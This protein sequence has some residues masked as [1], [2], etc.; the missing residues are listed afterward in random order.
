MQSE[1][2]SINHR[3][4]LKR[5]TVN[6]WGQL[7]YAFM[8]SRSMLCLRVSQDVQACHY[9]VHT[10]YTVTTNLSSV[11]LPMVHENAVA[12][13]LYVPHLV[14]RA[15]GRAHTGVH[16]DGKPI[17][18]TTRSV[19]SRTN[20]EPPNTPR[21]LQPNGSF[22]HDHQRSDSNSAKLSSKVRM[23]NLNSG[24]PRLARGRSHNL[25]S[26]FDAS[27]IKNNAVSAIF[28]VPHSF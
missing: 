14:C 16:S 18:K 1:T 6:T 20:F 7:Y 4:T 24:D 10:P 3:I 27:W 15:A 25:T 5:H 26:K 8:S 2:K 11:L 22:L 9:H 13:N 23:C 28:R 21:R 12:T 17:P 19:L